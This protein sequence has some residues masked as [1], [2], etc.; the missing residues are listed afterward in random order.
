MDSTNP[1]EDHKGKLMVG[2][3]VAMDL[4]VNQDL[5]GW[6]KKTKMTHFVTFLKS[7]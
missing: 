1:K 3:T 4:G 7:H 6:Q 5:K 2:T